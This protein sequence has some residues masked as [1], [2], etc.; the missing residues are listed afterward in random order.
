LPKGCVGWLARAFSQ[1][2]KKDV[3]IMRKEL[4]EIQDPAKRA[5]AL[6]ALA[7]LC[8]ILGLED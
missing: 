5:R 1:L 2:L 3:E 8:S 6:E 7:D 4:S